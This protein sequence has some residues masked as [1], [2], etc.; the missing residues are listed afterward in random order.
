MIEDERCGSP[1]ISCSLVECFGWSPSVPGT[2]SSV[3]LQQLSLQFVSHLK[4]HATRHLLDLLQTR[5]SLLSPCTLEMRKY[6]HTH[7]TRLLLTSVTVARTC[8]RLQSSM[9]GGRKRIFPC[10]KC[11]LGSYFFEKCVAVW[12]TYMAWECANP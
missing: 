10:Q 3:F 12:L 6:A 11:I 2:C 9:Y 5:N 7:T 8:A 1:E 4:R